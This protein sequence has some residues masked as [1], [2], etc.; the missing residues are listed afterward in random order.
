MCPILSQSLCL[1][2]QSPLG[3]GYEQN[4]G[5]SDDKIICLQCR[6]PRVNPLVEKIPWRREWLPIPVF[7]PGEFYGE[8]NLVGYSPWGSQ[9][10]DTTKP[11]THT[12]THTKWE[13]FSTRKKD[14]VCKR[15]KGCQADNY[16]RYSPQKA[17]QS[18]LS[19]LIERQK[20]ERGEGWGAICGTHFFFMFNFLFSSFLQS[21]YST[22]LLACWKQ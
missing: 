15:R 9:K 13:G 7:L 2:T 14:A 19:S 1:R 4:H 11:F 21:F 3:A 12:H 20:E 5:G 17:S 10:S 18:N 6:W 16:H 22:N 8:R